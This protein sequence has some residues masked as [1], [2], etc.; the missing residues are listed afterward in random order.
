MMLSSN[1]GSKESLY[2]SAPSTG[3]AENNISDDDNF[4]LKHT[5]D[6]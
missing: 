3:D 5:V 6:S 4:G 1:H 2:T